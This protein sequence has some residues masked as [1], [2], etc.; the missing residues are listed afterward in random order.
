[1]GVLRL[2]GMH[3][4]LPSGHQAV[5]QPVRLPATAAH[6]FVTT[7]LQANHAASPRLDASVDVDKCIYMHHNGPSRHYTSTASLV[8]LGNTDSGG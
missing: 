3:G 4:R 5:D 8:M 6:S 7:T 2:L 1:M